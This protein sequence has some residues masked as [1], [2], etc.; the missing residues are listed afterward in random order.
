MNVQDIQ[1]KF[2]AYLLTEK[3]VSHNTLSSYKQ[4]LEQFIHFLHKNNLNILSL[5]IDELKN[6]VHYLYSLKLNAR[7]IARKISTLKAFFIYLN[8]HCNIKNIAKDL[9]ITKI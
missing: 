4:D 1:I 7:S 6:F 5:T 3:R 8:M 2:E 9:H